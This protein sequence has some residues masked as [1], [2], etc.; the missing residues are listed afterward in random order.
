MT[1][2]VSTD[3]A[4]VFHNEQLAEHGGQSGIRDANVLESAL[5]RPQQLEPYGNPSPDIA[6][7]AAAYAFGLAKNHPFSD[8]NKRTSLA[9]TGAFLRLNGYDITADDLELVKVWLSLANGSMSESEVAEWLRANI[10]VVT[11]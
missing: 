7:L 8:G 10:A 5:A 11:E 2:W 3:A 4:L 9:V 6:A 1:T